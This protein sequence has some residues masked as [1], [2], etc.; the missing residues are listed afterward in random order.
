MPGPIKTAGILQSISA[1]TVEPPVV[2]RPISSQASHEAS[3]QG[4]GAVAWSKIRSQLSPGRLLDGALRLVAA[5]SLTGAAG[6]AADVLQQLLEERGFAVDRPVAGH[7]ASPAVVTRWDTGLAGPTLQ[8]SGHLDTVHLPFSP[9]RIVGDRLY[10]NGAVDMKGG[11]AACVEALCLLRDGQL[12]ECGS[13]LFTAYDLHECP[14]GDSRQ[15]EA[16]IRDGQVGDGVLLPEYLVDQLPIAGRGGLVWKA[17]LDRGSPA[18]HE[19]YMRNQPSLVA[20]ITDLL[21]TCS[22]EHDRLQELMDPLAG[23]E[24]LFVGQVHAGE[25][26]NQNSQTGWVE[27]TRRWLPGHSQA[28]VERELRALIEQVA[29]RT[30]V[31]IDLSIHPMRDAFLLDLNHSLVHAFQ[32][33][34][35][36]VQ[37]E[38]LPTGTKP[39][40]DDGNTFS[41]LAGIPAITHGPR[42][43]GAHTTDEWVDIADLSRVASVYAATAA[44]FCRD[45]VN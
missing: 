42:G 37:G 27:G 45:S 17:T 14:W 23:R 9:P 18:V 1:A 36:E 7:S 25:L 33:V 10:G 26:Y 21:Q 38:P 44:L 15:L 20:A 6:P 29:A 31:G 19:L 35:R 4:I 8:F 24:S 3:Q 41:S 2:D 22:T 43:A 34:M 39:F 40:V 5:P 32:N 12:L 16:L 11:L 28:A 30:G 13:V